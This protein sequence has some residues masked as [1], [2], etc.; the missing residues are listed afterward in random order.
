MAIFDRLKFLEAEVRAVASTLGRRTASLGSEKPTVTVS[1]GHLASRFKGLVL[2]EAGGKNVPLLGHVKDPPPLTPADLKHLSSGKALLTTQTS[3]QDGQRI[4][5]YMAL[6][7]QRP[8]GPLLLAEIEPL[9]LWGLKE[10]GSIA[11]TV[12]FLITDHSGN[13]LHSSFPIPPVFSKAAMTRMKSTHSGQFPLKCEGEEYIARFWAIFTKYE[14]AVPGWTVVMA[15]SKASV[16]VPMANFKITFPLVVFLSLLVVLLLSVI[17]IRRS[18]N[19][20]R[21]LQEGTRRIA[22]REFQTRVSIVSGDE[23]EELG[24]SFNAMA[25]RLGKQFNAM[26]VM[27]EIDRSILSTL[28]REKIVDTVLTRMRDLFPCDSVGLA[29]L[30]EKRPNLGLMHIKGHDSLK[31]KGVHSIELTSED[32]KRLHE[33]QDHFLVEMKEKSPQYLAPL[34]EP[35]LKLFLI[36]PIIL[37]DRPSG[38]VALGYQNPVSL[39]EEDRIS[40]RQL[41]DQMGVAL[42][43]A[44]L[45]EQLEELNWGTLY[46]LARAIDAKSPWTAGHSERVTK[47]AL[48]IGQVMGL[49]ERQLEDLHRA[50]LLHDIGKIGI[51][52]VI[53]DKR[54]KLTEEQYEIMRS[55]VAMGHRI[56]EPI[57][58]YARVASIVLQH[59][60]RFDGKGYPNGLSGEEI[61]LEARIFAV[62]DQFDAITSDRPYRSGME[63]QKGIEFIK[64]G[65]GHFFDPKVVRAYQQVMRKQERH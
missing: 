62:A 26:Q 57:S 22:M 54:G 35:H 44:R 63:K 59:H 18:L 37:K 41:A 11:P 13:V 51:P 64:Q 33:H 19:P 7:A 23:F 61:L 15:E 10:E 16:L 56:L 5:L 12:E 46:A 52:P 53:L 58:A 31:K 60:E 6:N 4:L 8:S 39:T 20:L 3:P 50:G 27:N 21:K 49:G 55:H 42:S 32:T 43:N 29:L 38:L 48:R 2:M 9:Y 34:V 36:L 30:E 45:L 24:A 17:Q 65:S 14:F 1:V 40:A 25:A 28:N 47:L